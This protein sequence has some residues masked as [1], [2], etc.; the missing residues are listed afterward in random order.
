M[1]SGR[2]NDRV[3]GNLN[4]GQSQGGLEKARQPTYRLQLP[5]LTM[6]SMGVLGV[7]YGALF[8]FLVVAM[9]SGVLDYTKG[10][11]LY[12]GIVFVQFFVAPFILDWWL[13]SLGSLEW[14]E[15]NRLPAQAQDLINKVCQKY[16][17]PKP[18]LGIIDDLSPQ[19]FTYGNTPSNARLVLSRG[20]IEMLNPDELDA[21]IAHELGHIQH[22]DFIFMTLAQLIPIV[23]YAIYRMLLG[24]GKDRGDRKNNGQ[25]AMIAVAA[26]ALYVVSESI[27]LFLSRTRE[28]WADRFSMENIPEPNALG[29]ALLKICTG[30]GVK[31]L[32]PMSEEE[33]EAAKKQKP[34][35]DSGGRGNPVLA[36]NIAGRG[37]VQ[38]WASSLRDGANDSDSDRMKKLMRWDLWNPW[39]SL[40]ELSSTHPMMGKRLVAVGE[41]S[42]KQQKSSPFLFDLVKPAGLRLS[43]GED[44]IIYFL[45]QI[46]GIALFAL[47]FYLKHS[48]QSEKYAFLPGPLKM[49]L[50]G[51][52]IAEIM[53]TYFIYP[54]VAGKSRPVITL[55]ESVTV[56]PLNPIATEV[57]GKI[58]GRGSAGDKLGAD[59]YLQ[60]ESGM[61]FLNLNSW[62]PF[63]NLYFGVSKA[64]QYI[65]REVVVK[66]WYRRAPMPYLEVK[67]IAA[68]DSSGGIALQTAF[69]SYL[70]KMGFWFLLVTIL[71]LIM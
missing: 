46:V 68:V 24:S 52:G 39:A 32:E 7:L 55:L 23:F 45:P 71:Y 11:L 42:Q 36:F 30:Y 64:R 22:R 44:L 58:I 65:G 25:L 19:A 59:L 48:P 13:K 70:W 34:S 8:V 53:K 12:V 6:T 62:I 15:M 1:E 33:L 69:R 41:Y 4:S 16:H 26:Y 47:D 61:I 51:Y 2:H 60:D 54:L 43:L 40:L 31:R 38:G 28:Y 20:L 67:E 57:R 9:E 35:T 66:G 49:A 56:T 50:L 63:Y 17:L 10:I 14:V 27:V 3:E 5:S 21:V 29:S 18:R 37:D